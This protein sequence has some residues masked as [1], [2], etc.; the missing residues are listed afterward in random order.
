MG[1]KAVLTVPAQ[2]GAVLMSE[3]V[4]PYIHEWRSPSWQTWEGGFVTW[5]PP[6]P[7]MAADRRTVAF[8]RQLALAPVVA[9]DVARM[10]QVNGLGYLVVD[11]QAGGTATVWATPEQHAQVAQQRLILGFPVPRPWPGEEDA[12]LPPLTYGT[13]ALRLDA[14]SCTCVAL[15]ALG[16]SARAVQHQLAARIRAAHEQ[17]ARHQTDAALRQM[18]AGYPLVDHLLRAYDAYLRQP[19]AAQPLGEVHWGRPLT[20]Q[21]YHRWG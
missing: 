17:L 1:T 19:Q 15:Q 8:L 4:A 13:L 5:C 6:T 3:Q 18:E 20:Q 9:T 7:C 11:D 12:F 21:R 14:T 2:R 16:G 10:L